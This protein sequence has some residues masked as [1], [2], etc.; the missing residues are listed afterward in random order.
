VIVNH[1]KSVRQQAVE[2]LQEHRS[3]RPILTEVYSDDATPEAVKQRLIEQG[4]TYALLSAESAFLSI[5]A[6]RY[7]KEPNLD[8]IL[9][10]HAAD[11]LKTSRVG[12][13][14]ERTE[15]ACLTLCLMLQPHV[16][17][18]LGS[19]EGFSDRGA[20]ARLLPAFPAD[21][22]GSRRIRTRAVPNAL[23][24]AWDT[25]IR[26]ILDVQRHG[27]PP[28]VL[29]LAPEALQTFDDYRKSLEPTIK[30]H[31]PHM[32]EWR[33]KLAGAVLRIAGLLHIATLER[34]E[35]RP[36]DAATIQRAI[37]IG[38]Y[39]D[40]HAR[41]M[42]R[43]M[44]GRRGQ[45]DAASVLDVLRSVEGDRI[46]RRNLWQRVKNRSGFDHD[47]LDGALATLEEYGWIRREIIPA[48]AGSAPG[49]RR[50]EVIYLNPAMQSQNPQNSPAGPQVHSFERFETVP[51]VNSA[52]H[53]VTPMS[54]PP[55]PPTGTDGDW[56]TGDE[57]DGEVF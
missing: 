56:R 48:K 42:F 29:I 36:V 7:A 50:S 34:P 45:S 53:N 21:F 27:T 6:G 3:K 24:Q 25:T 13:P 17:Q 47:D 20:A 9:N 52:P 22:I 51:P 15:R 30:A 38:T 19:V 43:M 40:H 46:T 14:T 12:K 2:T 23:V 28:R 4:G 49:G 5:V 26:R 55:L 54:P 11:E 31:G 8:T 1:A 10:G 39:F 16:M 57:E 41:I 44:H 35:E 33:A 32:A 18:K 37:T